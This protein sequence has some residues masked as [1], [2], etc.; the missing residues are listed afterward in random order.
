RARRPDRHPGRPG[1]ARGRYVDQVVSDQE[2][3]LEV[4]LGIPFPLNA[5][6]SSK[7]FLA[8]LPDFEVDAYVARRPLEAVTDKT[9]VDP[10]RLRKDLAAIRK[11]GYAT[12]LGERQ[13]GAASVAAPIF[14]HDGRVAAVISLAGPAPRFEPDAEEAVTG[15]LAAAARISAQLGHRPG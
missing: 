6:A 9:I 1:R 13:A 14:D 11:R 5:G 3:R 4:S 12:S 15:L 8:F 7:A 10:A 2:L